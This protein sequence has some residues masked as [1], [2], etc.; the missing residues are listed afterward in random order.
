MDHSRLR[1]S[2]R[3]GHAAAQPVPHRLEYSLDCRHT[4][5]PCQPGLLLLARLSA[6]LAGGSLSPA[7]EITGTAGPPCSGGPACTGGR[8]RMVWRA[9]AASA[10]VFGDVPEGVEP[11]DLA[12]RTAAAQRGAGPAPEGP[13]AILVMGRGVVQ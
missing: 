10:C 2:A 7:F 1:P 13:A 9:T 6:A 3:G 8:C 12:A 11:A 5:Q 4:G